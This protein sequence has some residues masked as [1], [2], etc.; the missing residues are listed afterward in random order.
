MNAIGHLEY[1]PPALPERFQS[2]LEVRAKMLELVMY[3]L[4]KHPPESISA[5]EQLQLLPTWQNWFS[6][7]STFTQKTT[8]MADPRPTVRTPSS[9]ARRHAR[10]RNPMSAPQQRKCLGRVPRQV[11]NHPYNVLRHLP[12]P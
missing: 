10:H 7:L 5:E 3:F 12:Q 11:A 6:K 4:G 8:Q 1:V 9:R 2:L